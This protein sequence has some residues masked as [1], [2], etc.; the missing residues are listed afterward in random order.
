MV[1][2]DIGARSELADQHDL[3][4]QRVVGQHGGRMSA[5][6]HLAPKCAA[7][8]ALIETVAE[9]IAADLK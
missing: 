7:L 5:L 2:G 8:T 1:S 4:A 3:V 6:E 9:E